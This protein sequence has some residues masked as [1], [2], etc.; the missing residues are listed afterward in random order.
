MRSL[1]SIIRYFIALL[2][3][4]TFLFSISYAQTNKRYFTGDNTD[5]TE[6]NKISKSA[7]RATRDLQDLPA[8]VSLKQYAPVPGHQGNQGTCVAWSTGYAARTIS[9]CI[10]HQITDPDKIKAAV[11]SPSYLYYYVK[12]PG[13]NNCTM[14]AKIEPALKTLRDTGA[15]LLSENIPDCVGSIDNTTRNKAKDYIIKAYTS[16]TNTFGRITKNEII[17][18]KKSL[19]EK[20]PVICSIK[21]FSSLFNVGKDGAW[22]SSA[23]DSIVGSHAICLIGYDDNKFG[24]SFEVMNSWGSDWGNNGFFWLTYD[25]AM[26]YGSY[27]L[28]LMDREVYNDASR[29]LTPQLRGSLDFVLTDDFG[30][31][32][33]LMPVALT[34]IDMSASIIQ[35]DSKAIF[36]KYIFAGNY[37]GGTKFKIKFTTNAPAFVY[38]FSI[39]DNKTVSSLFPY[40][41]NISPVVNSANE[42]IYLPS[43]EKH[44]TLNADANRDRICV[45]YSKSAID[46]NELK[47]SISKSS[48]SMYETIKSLYSN[49]MI[50]MKNINFSNN[51]ISFS[52]DASEQQLVCFF[53]DMNHQ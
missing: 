38:I 43:E 39:D 46:F 42:T 49:Q 19:S 9:Y 28:E 17:A 27:S 20:K 2:F 8:S 29:S 47:N 7:Q 53:I 26:Q 12:I 31:D 15:I 22:K 34:K 45:L 24:G 52:S 21:C 3:A 23:G 10:Q 5:E 51:K 14:G 41:A 40:A 6:F 1:N 4:C 44:Y 16:L 36:S 33:S 25:Q 13:D 11:F 30:N 50:P 35:D 48:S 32:Q 37:P 18:I